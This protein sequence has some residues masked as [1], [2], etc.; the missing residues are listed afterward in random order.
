M[1]GKKKCMNQSL[2]LV[3]Y[4][5]LTTLETYPLENSTQVHIKAD[6]IDCIFITYVGLCALD[7]LSPA[8]HAK[9]S[10]NASISCD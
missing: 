7:L 4:F 8:N 6:N 5:S 3:F 2:F 1:D 10:I 9:A